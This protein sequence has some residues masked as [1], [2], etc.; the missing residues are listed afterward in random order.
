VIL[1]TAEAVAIWPALATWGHPEDVAAVAAAA[2]GL[3]AA[4]DRKWVRAGWLMG[5]AIVMQLLAALIVPTV[6]GM[7]GTRRRIP[8]LLRASLLPMCFLAVFLIPD[9][10]DT[11]RILTRQ[12]TYPAV[13]HATPWVLLSPHYGRVTVGAGPARI[14]ALLVA[15]GCGVAANFWRYDLRRLIWLAAVAMGARCFFEAVMTPYYVMPAVTLAFIVAARQPGW[16]WIPA[17]FAGVTL[18]VVTHFHANMWIYW[19]Y[20]TALLGALLALSFPSSRRARGAADARP[21]ESLAPPRNVACS[22]S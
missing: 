4:A 14:G 22:G 10:H 6:A 16:R 15:L 12:P 1:L 19:L 20:T 18:T 17:L 2:F 21:I 8:L 13:N 3:T 7:A 9:F 5:V 11:W